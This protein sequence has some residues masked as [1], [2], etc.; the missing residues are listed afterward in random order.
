MLQVTK[1]TLYFK[2]SDN[3]DHEKLKADGYERVHT[4]A[5]NYV[6]YSKEVAEEVEGKEYIGA[7]T[8]TDN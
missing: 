5:Y 1:K 6:I 7:T 2:S 4:G 8:E 3:I